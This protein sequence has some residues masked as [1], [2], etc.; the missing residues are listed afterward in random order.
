MP[1][2]GVDA[3]TEAEVAGRFAGDVELVGRVPAPLVAVGRREAARGRGRRGQL[4]A[5]ELGRPWW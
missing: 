2:A 5:A 4:D 3:V 1:G